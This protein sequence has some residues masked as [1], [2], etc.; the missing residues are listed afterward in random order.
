MD[1]SGETLSQK[2]QSIR[3]IRCESCKVRLNVMAYTCRCEKKFCLKHLP[4][5]EHACAFNY[6]RSTATL[7]QQQLN[8]DGLA[9]KVD[10]I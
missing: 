9:V 2:P 7:L 4:S 1:S 3:I 5:T 10:K 6:R 8:V